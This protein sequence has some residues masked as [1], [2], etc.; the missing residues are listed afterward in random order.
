METRVYYGEYTLRHWLNLV[1]SRNVVLPNYQRSFVWDEKDI[2]RLLT[3]LASGQFVPPVTIAH[4]NAVEA[5]QNLILDGQ[6]RLTSILLAYLGYMP[7]KNLFKPS[8]YELASGDDSNEDTISS[9]MEWTYKMLL[10]KKL[11][12]NT[13]ALIEERL[14]DDERYQKLDIHY[15]I[16]KD[17]FFDNTFLGFSFIIPNSMDALGTQRYFSTLFRNMNYLGHK[18][19]S[20]ESRRSLYFLNENYAH[21]FDGRLANGKDVLCDVPIIENMQPHK[22]DFV[23]Y[24]STLSQYVGTGKYD[25]VLMGYSSY[26]SRESYYADYVS[27]I[28]GLEQESRQDKFNSFHIDV[29][30]PNM[31][32]KTRF[33]SVHTFIERNKSHLNLD[34][35]S[36]AFTS[37]IDADYWL[38]GLLY[39]VLFYGK[40]ICDEEILVNTISAEIALKRKPMEGD[41]EGEDYVKNPNRVLNMRLRMKRSIEIYEKYV[42]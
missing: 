38:F 21:Y 31:A 11:T 36:T 7:V 18:L 13:L 29:A 4:F 30:F 10:S 8:D 1:I 5:S 16:D 32:W 34:E 6:Q 12:E 40:S 28:V 20:L 37:W 2:K 35:K 15:P 14:R 19:S 26:S 39:W 9:P 42:R 27:Y 25:K 41:K 24:L 23:R 3:S 33:E 17:E 22:I